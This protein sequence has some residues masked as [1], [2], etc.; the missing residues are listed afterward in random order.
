MKNQTP[1][2]LKATIREQT[3]SL[4]G[5][6][7]VHPLRF[8]YRNGQKICQLADLVGM[9]VSSVFEGTTFALGPVPERADRIADRGSFI[10]S[11]SI[12][13]LLSC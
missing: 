6:R 1:S 2:C 9:T 4:Q 13:R 11:R 10:S 3:S 7:E 5:A 8:H 12:Q